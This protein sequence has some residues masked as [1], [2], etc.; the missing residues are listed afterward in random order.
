VF[1]DPGITKA[2]LA[3]YYQQAGPRMVDL[4][5]GR[6]VSLLRC[7]DGTAERCF[8]QKHAGAGFPEALKQMEIEES[9]GEVAPYMYF[10]STA[11]LVGAVQMGTVEFHIWGVR[12]DNL[13]R[14]DRIVFDLD[15]DEGLG[16]AR[17]TAAADRV[18]SLLG[19]IGLVS[20]PMVTGGKG[21]HVIVPLKRTASW[22][23]TTLFSRTVASMLADAEPQR[24]VATM[25]KA[26]RKGRIFID[27]LRNERGATAIAPYSVRARKGA[28]VAI[29]VT[30]AELGKLK[31]ANGFSVTDA[32]RRLK[33]GC[34]LIEAMA[35]PQHLG[36][37]VLERL[38]GLV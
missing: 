2:D 11:G 38:D 13:E 31:A 17:V 7:P 26:R 32:A 33:L 27:W 6:P 10:T 36:N 24:F 30:W 35:S 9:S 21:V 15:P 18:R 14:P 28:P 8:F 4:A 20:T 23:T 19:Q 25:A 5:G 22:D 1:R 16:F 37:T 34:P 3:R 29:P 12:T